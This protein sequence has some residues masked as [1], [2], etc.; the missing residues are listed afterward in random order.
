MADVVWHG[1]STYHVRESFGDNITLEELRE[2]WLSVSPL[3]YMEKLAAQPWRPQR[4]IYTKYDLS[5]P[6]ISRID[7][8]DALRRNKHTAQ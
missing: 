1:L 5:F 2:Y 6:S 8:M 4:Y 3:A 7:T